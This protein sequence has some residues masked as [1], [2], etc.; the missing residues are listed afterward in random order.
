MGETSTPTYYTW[1]FAVKVRAW[2]TSL[3]ARF[4]AL[5]NHAA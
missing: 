3:V 1:A 4:R 2:F 5:F